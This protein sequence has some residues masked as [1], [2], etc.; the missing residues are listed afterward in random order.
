MRESGYL[1]WG[2]GD[3]GGGGAADV[4]LM[5]SEILGVTCDQRIFTYGKN[6]NSN[7]WPL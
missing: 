3:G 1:M 5:K 4:R 2:G 6:N 7:K